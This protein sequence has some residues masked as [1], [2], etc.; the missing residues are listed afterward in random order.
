MSRELSQEAQ[1]VLEEQPE[2]V[3]PVLE[4]RDAL[5][6]HA[7]RPPGDLLGVVADVPQH[8]RMHHPRAQDLDPAA[9]LAQPAARAAAHEPPP[10]TPAPPLSTRHIPRP[11]P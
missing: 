9:L 1:V 4:H 7:E 2:V 3:D 5:D 11:E 6:P 10:P 8:L